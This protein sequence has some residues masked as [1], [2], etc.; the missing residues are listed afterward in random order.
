MSIDSPFLGR[1]WSFP[2]SFSIGGRDVTT[3]AGVD[4]VHQSV[5]VI[6]GT[7][8]G[9][10]VMQELFGCDL[11]HMM[12]AEIDRRLA[13]RIERLMRNALRDFEPRINVDTIDV[14]SSDSEVGCLYITLNY[15]IRGTNSRFNMVYPFYLLE[16]TRN[17]S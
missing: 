8:P 5:Q 15:T 14:S 13:N 6:L 3:V 17:G 1:G 16:A 12:F 4:D 11:Q 2:P 7:P 9:E 10:R